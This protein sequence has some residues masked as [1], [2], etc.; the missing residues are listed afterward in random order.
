MKIQPPPSV[1][2]LHIFMGMNVLLRHPISDQKH[3]M[4]ATYTYF[5]YSD[6]P[7]TL[8]KS[9]D[10]KKLKRIQCTH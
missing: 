4:Q 6:S 2:K 9:E 7:Y 8:E 10:F 3:A 5:L 1:E